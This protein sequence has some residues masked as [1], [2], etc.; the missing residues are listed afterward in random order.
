[1]TTTITIFK[2]DKLDCLTND[3][4]HTRPDHKLFHKFESDNQDN[5]NFLIVL[6]DRA[7]AGLL[8]GF[9]TKYRAREKL[10]VNQKGADL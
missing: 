2:N 4:T 3:Q 6:M 7:R 10:T 1:M 5:D 9:C 8:K